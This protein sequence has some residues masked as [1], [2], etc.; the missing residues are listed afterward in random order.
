[1]HKCYIDTDL[2]K[3]GIFSLE[4]VSQ[5]ENAGS[6]SEMSIHNQK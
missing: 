3:H 4:S 2:L 1:M 6:C 5:K